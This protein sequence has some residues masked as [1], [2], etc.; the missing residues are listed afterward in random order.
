[1][2]LNEDIE[3]EDDDVVAV[4]ELPEGF[5][6]QSKVTDNASEADGFLLVDVSNLAWR[7]GHAYE[8]L[9]TKDGR[10]SGHIYGSLRMLLAGVKNYVPAGTWCIVFCY[11]GPDSKKLRREVLPG[12]K[13]NRDDGRWNPCPEV[14]SVLKLLPGIHIEHPEREGD[15]AIAWAADKMSRTGKQV[16]VLSGDKDTWG[17]LQIPG[18][19]VY[20]PNLKAYVATEHLVKKFDG[21]TNP[22]GVYL[23]KSLFGDSS[24]CIKGIPRLLKKQVVWHIDASA[25]MPSA[26]LDSLDAAPAKARPGTD[27]NFTSLATQAKIREGWATVETNL[28][29][30]CPNITGFDKS[31]VLKVAIS[32]PAKEQFSAALANYECNSMMSSVSYFFGSP[33]FVGGL[34]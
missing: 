3:F 4:N 15:D 22:A 32:D 2:A 18:L 1:M 13:G 12:Y 30:I 28:K 24:D 9:T 6:K 33:F 23:H 7:A 26:F 14:R 34:E 11:D 8:E 16:I 17:L 31:N 19:K 20:S 29:V 27:E 5:A 21:L 10:K 25:G